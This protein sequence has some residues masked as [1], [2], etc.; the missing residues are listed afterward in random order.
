MDDAV[1]DGE[2]GIGE[3]SAEVSGGAGADVNGDT[4]SLS[5]RV[6]EFERRE[7]LRLLERNGAD[8]KGKKKT[9][10][11]LGISLASLYNKLQE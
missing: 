8:L 11:Q 10:S 5:Q 3:S 6:R 1:A 7:I 4:R 2:N 9:A